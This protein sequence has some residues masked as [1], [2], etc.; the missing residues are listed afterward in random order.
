MRDTKCAVYFM[1][2]MLTAVLCAISFAVSDTDDPF[3]SSNDGSAKRSIMSFVKETTDRNS[4]KF[5]DPKDRIA[6]FDQDGTLWVER[7]IYPQDIYGLN[8]IPEIL[9]NDPE[10]SKLEPLKTVMSRTGEAINKLSPE[11]PQNILAATLAGMSVEDSEVE[12]NKWIETSRQPRWNCPFTELTYGPMIAVMSY[13]RDNAY[14]TY[15]VNGGVQDFVRA[16]SAEVCDI[17]SEQV[18][19]SA[20]ATKYNYDKSGKPI[21]IKEPRLLLNDDNAGKPEGIRLMIGRRPQAS[22]GNSTGDRQMLEYSQAVDG[23]HLSMPALHDDADWEYGCGPAQGLPETKVGSFTQEL[24]DEAMKQNWVIISMKNDWKQ[25][26][27]FE[28]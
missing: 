21:L 19:G 12:V 5:V 11:N 13:F 18:I 28:P 23:K 1:A 26:F 7:P 14:R 10:L 8:R 17:P 22:F 20:G 4:S 27:S 9:K 3:P 2:I 15:I 6:T 25:I 16:Y 24:Y